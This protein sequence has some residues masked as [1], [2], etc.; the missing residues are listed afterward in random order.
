MFNV[1]A[2]NSA[3]LARLA[4][5]PWRNWRLF[6]RI[7]LHPNL[8][9]LQPGVVAGF[10]RLGWVCNDVHA[11]LAKHGG[12]ELGADRLLEQGHHVVVHVHHLGVATP[13]QIINTLLV[14]NIYK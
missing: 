3:R 6:N 10:A 5:F 9:L 12:T 2:T 1:V 14:V 11:G 7:F 13:D 4:R 8:F